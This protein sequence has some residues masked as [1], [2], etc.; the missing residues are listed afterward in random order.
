M[1][2]DGLSL[3]VERAGSG[4][5]VVLLHGFTGSGASWAPLLE[6]LAPD[7]TTLAVDLVGHGR[8]G[9]PAAN[10][11]YRM[12]RAVDDLAALL[13]ALGHERAAWL[14]YSLGG[15]TALQ[16]AVHRPEVVSALILEGATPGY[17]TPEERAARVA[18]D[19]ALA[20][21]LEREGLEAFVD[22]WQ[23][24]PLW[25]SQRHTLTD[26]QRAA[27]RRGRL[28]QHPAGLAGSLR[29]MGTGAQDWVGDRLG[30]V[31]VPVLLTA[32][33]LDTRFSAIAREMAAVI[34]DSAVRL[35]DNAGHAAH[36]ERPAAFN[37][38]VRDFLIGVR[39]RL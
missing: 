32:G 29:G 3:H 5:P 34:P 16:V 25:D 17:A 19:E 15:R 38:L 28:A 30:K 24:I 35:I 27:L 10:D 7:F 23:A 39:G 12:R 31:R 21:R 22:Y 13:H 18:A 8:S 1:E 11:R 4:P 20:L 2:I 9:H 33:T 14:G 6:V 37:T 26:E 36:L